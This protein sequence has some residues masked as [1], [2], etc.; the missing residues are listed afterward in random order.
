MT[1]R[2]QRPSSVLNSNQSRHSTQTCEQTKN[3]HSIQTPLPRNNSKPANIEN[4]K[5][6]SPSNSKM[7]KVNGIDIEFIF[8]KR[9]LSQKQVNFALKES[10]FSS[11]IEIEFLRKVATMNASKNIALLDKAE[12]RSNGST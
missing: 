5:I 11:P 10:K 9:G 12:K 4:F 2:I 8:K 6:N 7:D 1:Q 3:G